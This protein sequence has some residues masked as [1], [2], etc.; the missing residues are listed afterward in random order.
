MDDDKLYAVRITKDA[1]GRWYTG[2]W[3]AGSGPKIYVRKSDANRAAKLIND[4][5]K[6]YYGE[7]KVERVNVFVECGDA[8]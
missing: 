3:N 1:T 2:G 8:S 6:A 5:Y 4:C 7:A